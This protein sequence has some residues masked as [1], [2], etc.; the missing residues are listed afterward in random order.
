[1]KCPQCGIHYDDSERECPMCGARK[2]AFQKDASQL[3]RPTGKLARTS[4]RRKDGED[5]PRPSKPVSPSRS[6]KQRAGGSKGGGKIAVIVVILIALLMNAV[7]VILNTIEDMTYSVRYEGGNDSAAWASFP[8]AGVW[9]EPDGGFVLTLLPEDENYDSAY[10]VQAGGYSESGDYLAYENYEYE[11]DFPPEFPADEYTWWTVSLYPEQ[12]QNDGTLP[13]GD[14]DEY[15]SMGGY[16]SIFQS[17]A[18]GSVVYFNDEFG[19]IPWMEEG[20]YY[21]MLTAQG[22]QAPD[23]PAPDVLPYVPDD[24]PAAQPM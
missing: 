20:A 22:A 14:V 23:A 8:Y 19:D 1:M 17:R 2:P 21:P 5:S 15:L 13:E 24:A 9:Q 3:A 4:V 11:T 16:V 12:A 18:D 10:Q 6:K 7:P